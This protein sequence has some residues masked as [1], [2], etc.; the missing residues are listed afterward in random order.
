[1]DIPYTTVPKMSL[2]IVITAHNEGATIGDCIESVLRQ[3]YN[4]IHPITIIAVN[5]GS[6]D[7]TKEVI[8][9]Y[10]DRGVIG[11]H[12]TVPTGR[13]AGAANVGLEHTTTDLYLALDADGVL[14]DDAIENAIIWF[15][16]PKVHMVTGSVAARNTGTLW[17]KA[18]YGEYLYAFGTVKKGQ[19]NLFGVLIA[20]GCFSVVKTEYLRKLGGYSMRTFGEDL[21]LT[22]MFRENRWKVKYASK[23]VCTVVDP[24]TYEDLDKQ[25]TRWNT[26][27]IENFQVRNWNLFSPNVWVGVI[28]YFYLTWAI[29][30]P[31]FLPLLIIALSKSIPW[32]FFNMLMMQAIV[33]W[34]PM[35]IRAMYVGMPLR[36]VTASLW[37]MFVAQYINVWV[38]LRT[39]V[40][41]LVF[42]KKVGK[43]ERG[44]A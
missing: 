19:D 17:E 11:I 20:S 33:V 37:P 10:A 40:K 28:M 25:L 1:M 22:L 16:D 34:L 2:T 36:I 39:L 6:K 14:N 32:A 12:N 9:S 29:L 30:G 43:W 4:K 23:A 18:R 27:F 7:N 8:D 15:N 31:F 5:D 13:K 35:Y 26:S 21:D 42:K 41:I 38:L 44:H 3:T 24:H